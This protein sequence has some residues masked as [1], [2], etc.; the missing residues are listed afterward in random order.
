MDPRDDASVPDDQ[1]E[2]SGLR[3]S[4]LQAMAA[5]ARR[6]R[7]AAGTGPLSTGKA[8][9]VRSPTV[10]GGVSSPPPVEGAPGR[11]TS[12]AEPAA[13]GPATRDDADGAARLPPPPSPPLPPPPQRPTRRR[14]LGR[15]AE[16]G[17]LAG[18]VLAAVLVVVLSTG[19]RSTTSSTRSVARARPGPQVTLLTPPAAPTSIPASPS[20]PPPQPVPSTTTA[21]VAS[22]PVT[23]APPTPGGAPQI[24]S[25][26]PSQGAAGQTV[27]ISGTNLISADG[28]IL[29]RFNGSATQ[30]RCPTQTSCTVTVPDMGSPA[31]GVPVTVT[32][33]AG[34]SNALTFQYG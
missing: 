24:S 20:P 33:A 22:A 23:T 5:A 13:R 19:G 1:P 3:D 7:A 30:T 32:T 6:A 29:A 25:L 9:L 17:I 11:D 14:R 4:A 8:G 27:V 10:E 16:A 34:T 2:R 15:A 28:Q 18:V 21:P 31:S 12:R 26:S